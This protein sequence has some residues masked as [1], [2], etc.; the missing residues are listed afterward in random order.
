MPGAEVTEELQQRRA[1]DAESDE[2]DSSGKYARMDDL[3]GKDRLV[4]R[5]NHCEIERRRRNKMTLYMSELSDMVPTC[6]AL[7]RKPDK[8]TILRMAVA[9]MK[10]LKGTRNTVTDGTYKP[11]FLT[12]QE[13][14]HLLL[15]AADGFL[16]TLNCGTGR[17]EY[18]SDSVAAVLSCRQS[19]WYGS[20][21]YDHIHPEDISKVREQLS[22]QEPQDSGRVLDFKTGTVKKERQQS[23][24][25]Q[26]MGSRRGFICRMKVGSVIADSMSFAHLNRLKR[27]NSLGP[28]QDGQNYA[29]LHCNGYIKNCPPTNVQIEGQIGEEHCCL[30]AIGRL[31]VTSTPNANDLSD[32]NSAAE[33]ISRH[34]MDGKFSFVDQRVRGLLGYLPSELLKKTCFEFFHPEDQTHVKDSFEQVLKVRDQVLSVMYRFRAKNRDYVWLRTSVLA[35][36]NP[37]SDDVE[38]IVCTNTAVKTQHST[39]E[40]PTDNTE[41]VAFQQSRLDYNLPHHDTDIYSPTIPAATPAPQQVTRPNSQNVYNYEAT[42]YSS[43]SHVNASSSSNTGM[44]SNTAS[45]NPTVAPWNV[46]QSHPTP[47]EYQYSRPSPQSPGHTYT[48]LSDSACL[49]AAPNPYQWAWQTSTQGP[50]F[51]GAGYSGSGPP[52]QP[53][54]LSDTLRMLDPSGA[55]SFEELNT[56]GT[57][58]E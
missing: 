12:D 13:L 29:V 52:A 1:V 56:F 23:L 33:F 4:S 9:H 15:E 17:V 53:H 32:T 47:E 55:T 57:T 19:D 6:S 21:I 18:V 28:A 51:G 58:F 7:A 30:I 38:Y 26:C 11:S 40:V 43:P 37:Y 20:C 41:H 10:T 25:R 16:F 22:T 34:S 35:F 39:K 42:T 45:T 14:K 44:L 50:D 8:L 24:I 49:T 54:E 27:K 48:Q 3:S 2:D 36:L 5:E 46:P 31:Q